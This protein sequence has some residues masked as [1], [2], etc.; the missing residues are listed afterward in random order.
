MER[1]TFCTIGGNL[2]T[3]GD[4]RGLWVGLC[5]ACARTPAAGI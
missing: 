2:L 5:I 1:G 3:W 4:R